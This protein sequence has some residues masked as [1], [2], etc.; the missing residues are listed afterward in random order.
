M[1]H[2][3]LLLS[4]GLCQKAGQGL[5]NECTIQ[6]LSVLINRM[7]SSTARFHFCRLYHGGMSLVGLSRQHRRF[8]GQLRC[9]AAANRKDSFLCSWCCCC[10]GGKGR[11]KHGWM[12]WLRINTFATVVQHGGKEVFSI[13]TSMLYGDECR[14]SNICFA[15]RQVDDRYS[16]SRVL[17]QASYRGPTDYGVAYA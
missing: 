3:L 17:A 4:V 5:V 9:C 14:V 13:H 15:P 16:Y 10:C 1:H 6:F 7:N 8:Q 11:M 2:Y 12:I